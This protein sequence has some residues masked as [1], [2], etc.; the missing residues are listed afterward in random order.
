M[1]LLNIPHPNLSSPQDTFTTKISEVNARL[2]GSDDQWTAMN[3]KTLRYLAVCLV[4]LLCVTFA[5]CTGTEDVVSDPIV[6]P[7][8]SEQSTEPTENITDANN[9]FAF[10]LYKK[11]T[12][13]SQ[14]DTNIF[15]SP[16]SLSSAFAL[17]YEGA[18]GE[19]AEEI[20][21]VFYFPESIETLRN[22]YQR[23]NAGI[24]AEDPNYDLQIANALWAEKTYPFLNDYVTTA[25]KYYSAN[26]SN[27]DFINHPG[28]SRL[29]IN[30]WAEE[31][32]RERI[33]NLIPEG[34]I[35]SLTR[36]VITN[37]IYFKGTWVTQFDQNRT[38]NTS[39][40]T[41]SGLS[42]TVEMMQKT[43]DDALFG[44]TETDDLKVLVMPYD[45]ENE[46]EL[47]MVVLL[48]TGNNLKAAED[49]LNTGTLAELENSLEVQNVHVSFPKFTL[50]TEYSLSDTLKEMG[51]PTAFSEAADFSGMDGTQ[52]LYVSDVVHKAY[53]N[54]NEEGTEAAAATAVM[55]MGKGL[56]VEDPVPVFRADHPFIFLIQDNETGMI[57]FIGRVSSP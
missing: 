24:N 3:Q 50:E 5:G 27:L 19:T 9:K 45:H 56:A 40:Y 43:D 32:T 28:E 34:G 10:D 12:S 20:R 55:M 14:L 2:K 52:Y 48:P 46:K 54:V 42:E 36:L 22:G 25:E 16:L 33:K 57:L 21:S 8:N 38:V 39:F 47:S 37:A 13:E 53:V 15:V 17:T 7:E 4:V 30:T 41:L 23:I 11:L 29:I 18:E 51:M 1:V 26:T 49:V 44:Y 6:S 35:N 31:K